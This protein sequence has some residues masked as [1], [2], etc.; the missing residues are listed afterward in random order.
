MRREGN[1]LVIEPA[2][3]A[4][5]NARLIAFL[6]TLEPLAGDDEFPDIEDY[7]PEPFEL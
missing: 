6:D 2:S 5:P 4:G 3:S 1:T 7:P